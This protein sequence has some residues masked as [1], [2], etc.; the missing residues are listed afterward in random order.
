MSELSSFAQSLHSNSKNLL[1][2]YL[3]SGRKC[4]N[5]PDKISKILITSPWFDQ[6]WD[7]V[8]LLRNLSFFTKDEV[9]VERI[10]HLFDPCL[11]DAPSSLG[12]FIERIMHEL[13]S[14]STVQEVASDKACIHLAKSA[15]TTEWKKIEIS[16]VENMINML[17][18]F[19]SRMENIRRSMKKT[20]DCLDLCDRLTYF[21]SEK[22]TIENEISELENDV[23]ELRTSLDV[24][25]ASTAPATCIHCQATA[26]IGVYGFNFEEFCDEQIL[27]LDYNHAIFDIKTR[28]IVDIDSQSGP[29]IEHD[30]MPSSKRH[31]PIFSFHQ[32]YLNKL[33]RGD[34]SLQLNDTELQDSLLRLAQILGRLDR[35]ALAL[36]AINEEQQ[37]STPIEVDLP[38]LRFTFPNHENKL[39]LTLDLECFVTEMISVC[40]RDESGL[41]SRTKEISSSVDCCD[42]KS[43][44]RLLSKYA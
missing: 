28:V 19:R 2:F 1:H 14:K 34:I 13:L 26:Q 6:E 43:L 31:D 5:A 17:H 22:K 24:L 18:K 36:K 39:L 35:C 37:S 25:E 7:F 44:R 41:K 9:M 32:G 27:I 21:W 23:R 4:E 29:S 11:R 42:L 10:F 20:K 30:V 12:D 33:R 16:L 15:I 3:R 40:S 38:H 8:S